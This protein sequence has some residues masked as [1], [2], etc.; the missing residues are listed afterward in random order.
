M[1]L[2][3][4][5]DSDKWESE[6]H[7]S[8]LEDSEKLILSIDAPWDESDSIESLSSDDTFELWED[9]IDALLDEIFVLRLFRIKSHLRKTTSSELHPFIL[10]CIVDPTESDRVKVSPKTLTRIKESTFI[11]ESL[12][13]LIDR[14]VALDFLDPWIFSRLTP[15]S[16]PI[17]SCEEATI[18]GEFIKTLREESARLIVSSVNLA[19]NLIFLDSSKNQTMISRVWTR[20][21]LLDISLMEEGGEYS[22]SRDSTDAEEICDLSRS[23]ILMRAEEM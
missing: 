22:M 13:I 11:S 1:V 9:F 4:F 7:E 23:E 6:R 19:L 21:G 10:I 17:D 5:C 8:L 16:Y 14:E 12:E 18:W 15:L 2:V 3:S 20:A